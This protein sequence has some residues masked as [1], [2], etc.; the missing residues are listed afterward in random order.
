MDSHVSNASNSG[1]TRRTREA[2]AH[3]RAAVLYS[4]PNRWRG[5]VAAALPARLVPAEMRPDHFS[6]FFDEGDP[7]GF[8]VNPVERLKF[9]RTLEICGEGPLGRVLELGCAVGSFTELLAPRA[10]EVLALDVSPA[11]VAQVARRLRDDPHVRV[12]AMT[13]PAE[14]PGGTFDLVVASDVLYYLPRRGRPTLPREDRGCSCRRRCLCRGAL[15]AEDGER[16]ERRRNPRHPDCPHEANARTQRTDES[17]GQG[18]PT[19]SIGTRR[20][21]TESAPASG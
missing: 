15:R 18:A 3:A 1:I 9:R 11:A 13:I 8:D 6:H 16:A 17:S 20:S 10:T 14:F 7:F 4:V 2:L 21:R 12:E 19:G 5:R